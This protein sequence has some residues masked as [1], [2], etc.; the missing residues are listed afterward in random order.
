MVLSIIM[1]TVSV[2][3]VWTTLD[4]SAYANNQSEYSTFIDDNYVG[5]QGCDADISPDTEKKSDPIY[6]WSQWKM[7]YSDTASGGAFDTDVI[8][9]AYGTVQTE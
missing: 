3:H 8:H 6:S 5:S 1:A 4:V 7:T 2:S 9:G